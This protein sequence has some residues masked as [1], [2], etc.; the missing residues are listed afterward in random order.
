MKLNRLTIFQFSVILVLSFFLEP[1]FAENI[2]MKQVEL[3]SLAEKADSFYPSNLDSTFY[4]ASQALEVINELGIESSFEEEMYD[5]IGSVHRRRGEAQKAEENY[6]KSISLSTERNNRSQLSGVYNRLGLLYRGIGRYEDA[7]A[8]YTRSIEIRREDGDKRGE[9]GAVNNLGSL[10]QAMGDTEK[11]YENFR[12]SIAIREELGDQRYLSS[13]ILNLGNWMARSARFD[14]AMVYY[15]RYKNIQEAVGDTAAL[16]RVIRNIGNTYLDRGDYSTALNNYLESLKLN[17]TIGA[18]ETSLGSDYTQIGLLY[19]RQDYPERAI[20]YL[21]KALVIYNK[22]QDPESKGIVLLNMGRA[23]EFMENPDS[24]LTYYDLAINEFEITNDLKS[25]AITREYIGLIYLD[26]E[27]FDTALSFFTQAMESYKDNGNDRDFSSIYSNIG[28]TYNYLEDFRNGLRY[29]LKSL[30]AANAVNL[31]ELKE[32]ALIGTADSYGG[33]N[34]FEKAYEYRLAHA[35][36]ADSIFNIEKTKAVEELITKYETEQKDAEIA[37]LSSEQA[38]IQAQIEQRNA[39]NKAQLI[40]IISLLIGI[41]GITLWVFYSTR[42]KRIIAEQKELLFQSEIDGLMEKQQ[43][44]SIGAMLEGQ[45][46]ERKR[47]AAELH[48]RLGS[49]LSLVKL[50]FSSLND[51]IKEKQPDLYGFYKEGSEFLDDAFLE[52]RAI[53]KEMTEGKVSG[54]GIVKDLEDL[55]AKISKLGIEIE[56]RIELNKK[57]DSNIEMNI[58]R[59][60]QEALSNSLKYSKADTIELILT[61]HEHL[62]LTVKDNGIGFD[63]TGYKV[64]KESGLESYGVENMENRVKLL[65]GNFTLNTKYGEGVTI[66]VQIPIIQK[67][68]LWSPAELN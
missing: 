28:A 56:S 38:K 17:E 23:Y 39:E 40:A 16:A 27:E 55:L 24:A 18:S 57:L 61:D 10:Y 26:L 52:V 37:L 15:T 48:D 63:A 7:L 46:K 35:E 2:P 29:N 11:A 53:I 8:S 12:K 49:I 54:N 21:Q 62:S 1:V 43:L 65:G 14:S 47:L 64:Q 5:L 30:E 13:A 4:Y 51:E 42:K 41:A 44:S 66:D 31:L 22:F 19:S 9:A 33:L 20:E 58:Y 3:E 60:I 68:D 45:D 67:E 6:L 36:V 32:R 25:L 50:Y 59:V 34:M